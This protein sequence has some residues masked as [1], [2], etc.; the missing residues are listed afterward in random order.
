MLKDRFFCGENIHEEDW[1]ANCV[2]GNIVSSEHLDY[3]DGKNFE[4]DKYHS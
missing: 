3:S 1:G 2:V 4:Y